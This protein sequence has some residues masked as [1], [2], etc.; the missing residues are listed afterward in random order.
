[1]R[2]GRMGWPEGH[3]IADRWG[4]GPTHVLLA[5]ILKVFWLPNAH[6]SPSSPFRELCVALI[7]QVIGLAS[8]PLSSSLHDQAAARPRQVQRDF[9]KPLP[10]HCCCVLGSECVF[11]LREGAQVDLQI[12][13]AN[14]SVFYPN[15]VI[16]YPNIPAHLNI[17]KSILQMALH[18]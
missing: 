17:Y 15:R 8:Q 5:K 12:G 6:N 13:F 3:H 18:A 16:F 11:A 1:M 10:K 4:S 2:L 14:R 9:G 7:E